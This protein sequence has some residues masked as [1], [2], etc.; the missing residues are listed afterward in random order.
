M[1]FVARTAFLLFFS[2]ITLISADF[3]F[4]GAIDGSW[5]KVGNWS[6]AQ[7]PT[8]G[9]TVDVPS[10]KTA[11]LDVATPILG[12]V[13]VGGTLT[14]SQVLKASSLS[15]SGTVTLSGGTI[16]G[17]TITSGTIRCTNTTNYLDGVTLA[18]GTTLDL[19]T[20]NGAGCY[21]NNTVTI[22]GMVLLGNTAGT[23]YGR[24]YWN[25]TTTTWGGGR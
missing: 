19:S 17:V 14:I 15:N 18:F 6:P 4:T 20:V 13:T 2:V 23:T 9:K 22:N 3:T 11:T 21:L 7:I 24:L 10:G 1:N 5:N 8:A 16:S 12:A 25:T